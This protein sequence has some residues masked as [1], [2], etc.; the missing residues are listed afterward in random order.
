MTLVVVDGAGLTKDQQRTL[1]QA[2]GTVI[3]GD[4]ATSRAEYASR[5]PGEGDVVCSTDELNWAY[6]NAAAAQK[7]Q[8]Q[9]A[10]MPLATIAAG[11]AVGAA[12]V[13]LGV[14]AAKKIGR[15]GQ[16]T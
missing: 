13:G 2:Y 15:R 1:E 8:Q 16:D 4:E 5:F 6:I 12:A 11:A 9:S 14:L 10:G 3:I 7:A